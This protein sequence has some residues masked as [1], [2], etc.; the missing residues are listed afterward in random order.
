MRAGGSKTLAV[1]MS[2]A[3]MAVSALVPTSPAAAATAATVALTADVVLGSGLDAPCVTTSK[4]CPATF[5]GLVGVQ[6][7]PKGDPDPELHPG[8]NRVTYSI[9][10][11]AC[12][13]AGLHAGEAGKS[14]VGAGT[15]SLSASGWVNGFCG[16]SE[17]TVTGSLVVPATGVGA[18]QSLPVLLEL[19]DAGGVVLI[20]G[21][22]AKGGDLG[23]V[24]GIGTIT[25]VP[26]PGVPPG[27][28][29]LAKTATRFTLAATLA[30]KVLD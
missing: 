5:P 25:A 29:C 13:A 9:G 17:T 11:T 23:N 14:P 15:C 4:F 18:P 16:L 27:N 8:G 19:T 12:L 24:H 1:V 20:T 26:T 7:G 22:T 21:L 28:S 30:M 10:S 3:A 6:F 2:A